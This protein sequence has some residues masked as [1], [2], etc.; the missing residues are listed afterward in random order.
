MDIFRKQIEVINENNYIYFNP[1]DI[2]NFFENPDS[3]KKIL[4][5]IDDAYSS[6]YE[7]AWP[8]LKENKI[9]FI[10]FVSTV[11]I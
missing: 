6:F 3:K 2:D 11:P 4:I 10:F 9:P 1:K 7:Y 5:T 8:Y